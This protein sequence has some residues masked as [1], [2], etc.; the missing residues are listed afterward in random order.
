MRFK[1]ITL[2]IH[3]QPR[4]PGPITSDERKQLAD[5]FSALMDIGSGN[6]ISENKRRGKTHDQNK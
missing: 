4:D 2:T 1:N 3:I 6:E 5:F